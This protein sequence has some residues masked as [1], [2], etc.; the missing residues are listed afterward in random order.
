MKDKKAR[1]SLVFENDPGSTQKTTIKTKKSSLKDKKKKPKDR[2]KLKNVGFVETNE[3]EL[4]DEDTK[5]LGSLC[6]VI[7]TEKD[8]LSVISGK[9]HAFI[10]R[11][12]KSYL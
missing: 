3:K 6:F 5:S 1:R 9:F 10:S 7:D 11:L 2:D 4:G 8:T 12:I